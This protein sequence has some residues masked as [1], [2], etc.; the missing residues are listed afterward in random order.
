MSIKNVFLFPMVL[1]SVLSHASFAEGS[2]C[3]NISGNYQCQGKLSDKDVVRTLSV[4]KTKKGSKE[5]FEFDFEP[6]KNE[7]DEGFSAEVPFKQKV[8]DT[9]FSAY[10]KQ[11]RLIYS[12]HTKSPYTDFLI[13]YQVSLRSDGSFNYVF[14]LNRSGAGTLVFANY[15]C[16]KT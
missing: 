10:C 16:K 11:N 4:V 13:Q 6:A 15:I 7:I 2:L 8:D 12:E 9:T 5:K 3:P 14:L 1:M